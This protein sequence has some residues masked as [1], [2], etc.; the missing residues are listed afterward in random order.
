MS[1]RA[2]SLVPALL[3]AA[4]SAAAAQVEPHP[5]MLRNPDISRTQIVFVYADD[6]WLVPRDGGVATPLASP[7][8]V[9]AMPRFSPD[10]QAIAFGGNYD[11][12][13]D[14]YVLPVR[15]G[16]PFRVTHHPSREL[17]S[18]WT[19]DGRLL[20]SAAGHEGI[21][22]LSVLFTV[23]PEGGLP[24][25]APVPYGS[26][27]AVSP[28]G[29]WL[30]YMPHTTD[31]RT[32]KRYRGG[33]ATDIW[34]MNLKSGAARQ[35]TTWEGTDT[36]PLWHGKTLYYVSDELPPHRQNVWSLEPATGKRSP[37]TRFD[38][39]DVKFPAIGPG[40]D[41]GGEIVFQSGTGLQV[42]D[43]RTGKCR[44][45]KV[46]I[47]GARPTLRPR[48]VD[49]TKFIQDWA[50][51]PSGK[52]AL[53]Q[54]RGDVWSAPA[55]KGSPRN[56]TRTS[57][58]AER[59]PAWS[60]D[61]KWIA[62]LSDASGE[63]ELV[64]A[65]AESAPGKA[66]ARRVTKDGTCFR[67]RPTWSPDSKKVALWDKTN[68][69]SVV[70]VESGE[71]RVVDKD[72]WEVDGDV[73][74]LS[75]SHDSR[76]LAYAK[77]GAGRMSA[78][79]LW[80]AEKGEKTR[81]TAEVFND[82]YP[83]FDRA[84]DYLY[85]RSNR[86][87]N[88]L[89]GEL[90]TTFVY[91]GSEILLVVPLRADQPS[92]F[93][94]ESDEEKPEEK[95]DEKKDGKK[96]KGDEKEKEGAEAGAKGEE[97]AVEDALTGTWEGTLT[98]ADLPPGGMPFTCTLELK[99]DGSVSGSASAAGGSATIGKG[100]F[101]SATGALEFTATSDDGI[102]WTVSGKVAGDAV[103]G[104]AVNS[105]TGTT[106]Q[107]SA[108]RTGKGAKGTAGPGGPG[109]KDGKKKDGKPREKV[110]IALEGFERRAV[111][112]P[113]KA[114]R[115]GK[116]AV[117]SKGALLYVRQGVRGSD[118]E[119]EIQLFDPG[120]EK[121]EEKSVAKGAGRF[122][123]SADGK[124]ILIPKGASATIQDASAGATGKPVVTAGM[125]HWVE[126]REEWRQLLTE[127]WRLQR[128]FFY[129]PGLH[130]LD[131]P[132]MKKR[133]LAM[134]EDCVTRQDV[135]F[136]ISEM[137]SELNVGHAYYSGGDV[138]EEPSVPVGVLGCDF[139]LANGAYRIARIH[140]GAP[141]DVDARG[142]LSQPGVKVKEGDFLLA[143]N[144]VPVDTRKD[145]WAAFLG[146][147]GRTVTL[148][149]SEKP[150]PD[151]DARDLVVT[152]LASDG[153]L[154]YRAWIE[155]N[156]AAVEKKTGGRVGYIYV[157]D[158]GVNGQNNLVR[159]FFGQLAK[160][161]LIV[162]ERW[163]G[164]GQIPTRFVELLDR[165]ITNY[166]ARR[167]GLDWPWPPDAHQGPKCML[168]NGHAG[169]GGDAFPAYFR[170]RKL[171]KLI[172]TRTWGG[173]VG[174]SGNP[175]LIDGANMTVPTFGYYKKD[176]TWGIEGHGV[177]PDI[178]VVDDPSRMK[179]GADPQ[180]DAAIE[181]MLKELETRPYRPPP[182]PKGPD[183][184]GM[185]IPPQDR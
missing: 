15:G 80:N 62:W 82:S 32:W 172:G 103:T 183:R 10:G 109:G 117:N 143:V 6:L 110:E 25:R 20:F 77:N 3:L 156:R 122:E 26:I 115:F 31:F 134:L 65:P 119:S 37:I 17:L 50:I 127:A 112:L 128:D 113:V 41:G 11:G 8:G 145:P 63:Y 61:G 153:D 53:V 86:H 167:D 49:A 24:Q 68:A 165:P 79:W 75:W 181:L 36:S 106:Y 34:L 182:R 9:E 96:E 30:A 28:D 66:E 70:T 149:V 29:E 54:A 101:D 152:C 150:A 71:T 164:G 121:K 184:S 159:Q 166:W 44:L 22:R 4:A 120:D 133:H 125:T 98:G 126:P 160:E 93:A 175:R 158:T 138:G 155:R 18:D 118:Q 23:P 84:G 102:S 137:I 69:I 67:Y 130:G 74:G 14:L 129:E 123:L 33:L 81:V 108:K 60:P 161:A 92:P 27:G 97:K 136:V 124:K 12:N 147:A 16:V 107:L 151:K 51:S 162:D 177:D 173:L 38:D 114:G 40:P 76:W 58:V 179:D 131:W 19:P 144:G 42:L 2:A 185:G 169:S 148:T 57:S 116:L 157:P 176:G 146:T 59:D 72:P 140:E 48:A 7:P 89:Y 5:G 90:D 21:R 180:L 43:L 87:F 154:R 13:D 132:A 139:V 46:T 83:V 168:V 142:P 39:F 100:T 35:A 111:P 45:V 73:V 99:A 1:Y 170:E 163:N 171:G 104:T 95:K 178:V 174:I 52:R 94:P 56:L 135:G 88:P 141:W 85:F 55:E 78:I 47:P 64:V 105:K 91:A